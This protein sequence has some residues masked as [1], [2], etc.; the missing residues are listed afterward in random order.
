MGSIKIPN[1]M[2]L[3]SRLEDNSIECVR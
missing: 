3:S 1:E 2:K